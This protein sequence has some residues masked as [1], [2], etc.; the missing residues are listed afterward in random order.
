MKAKEAFAGR[1]VKCPYCDKVVRIPRLEKEADALPDG[2]PPAN[3]TA[4]P[5][6][7]SSPY[8][9]VKEDS[10]DE[11]RPLPPLATPVVPHSLSGA[12]DGNGDE[13][14]PLPPLAKPAAWSAP[15]QMAPAAP[16]RRLQALISRLPRRPGA[17]RAST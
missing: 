8:L 5:L 12:R 4:P 13:R 9:T 1:K 3:R 2:P 11:R 10:N 15:G 7:D 16:R 14:S 6:A 17:G